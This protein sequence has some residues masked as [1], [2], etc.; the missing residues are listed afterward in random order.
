MV[1]NVSFRVDA[2]VGHWVWEDNVYWL[3]RALGF[4]AV[5]RPDDAASDSTLRNELD[6]FPEDPTT[7]TA[8][9][10]ALVENDPE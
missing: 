4:D 9:K 3:R 10:P 5:D 7:D 8:P 6:D 2:R 1:L